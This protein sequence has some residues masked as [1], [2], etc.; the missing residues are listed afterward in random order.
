[1]KN[2][3]T[4]DSFNLIYV[5]ICNKCKEEYI[6]ETGEGKTKLG[7]RVRVYHQQI[8]QPQCQQLKVEGNLGV[9]G[10]SEFEIFPL[11]QMHSQDKN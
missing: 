10:N 6:G 3:F 7:D 1:M 2:C 8:W 5:V 4:C 11:S 9:C